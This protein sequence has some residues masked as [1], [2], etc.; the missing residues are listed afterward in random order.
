MAKAKGERAYIDYRHRWPTEHTLVESNQ[1]FESQRSKHR[2][3]S[4]ISPLHRLRRRSYTTE[5][6]KST[7]PYDT[8]VGWGSHGYPMQTVSLNSKAAGG[9]RKRFKMFHHKSST[10]LIPPVS[11]AS[12]A[13]KDSRPVTPKTPGQLLR[14]LTGPKS[15]PSPRSRTVSF[16]EPDKNNTS[17]DEKPRT[18]LHLLTYQAKMACPLKR[19]RNRRVASSSATV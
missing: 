9:S 1:S 10:P 5:P 13:D 3:R 8:G 19:T 16:L 2:H 17:E 12:H 18:S 15:S 4:F 11:N 7:H 6:G 14:F